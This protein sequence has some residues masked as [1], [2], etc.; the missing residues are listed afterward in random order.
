MQQKTIPLS[1][2]KIEIGCRFSFDIFDRMGQV[3]LP[4]GNLVLSAQ[5]VTNLRQHGRRLP[6]DKNTASAFTVMQ[7][8]AERLTNLFNDIKEG[9]NKGP[10]RINQIKYLASDFIQI[11]DQEPDASFASIHL[12]IHH[13]YIV[14]HSL[15]AA[16]VCARLSMTKEWD[17]KDR[18]SLIAAALTHDIGMLD[19][20]QLINSRSALSE[21]DI[22]I[23]KTHATRS[24]QMLKDF[25]VVDPLW[26]EAIQDHHEYL[27]GHGYAEKKGAEISLSGRIMALADSYSA[28]LRP[29]PH[30]E[31]LI[32]RQAL[33]TLYSGDSASHY[34]LELVAK[35][36]WDFGFYPPGSLLRLTNHEMAVAV[37]NT[38][39]VLDD[40]LVASLTDSSGRPLLKPVIRNTKEPT[41]NIEKT[42]DPSMA[43][44][45]GRMFEQCW[46]LA[47]STR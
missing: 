30:R 44:R 7:R 41:F 40:P 28:M 23:I 3:L 17:E 42:L 16:M 14:V 25:G 26:L 10:Q 33:Q 36:I 27:D 32:A 15:M 1:S 13:S 45:A 5:E 22:H 21:A 43:A 46:A 6:E 9:H 37:R 34:D 35:L 2:S 20:Y 12:N 39:G 4:R 24:V 18:Q 11:A 31:R 38:P 19:F 47:A 8:I 29:R